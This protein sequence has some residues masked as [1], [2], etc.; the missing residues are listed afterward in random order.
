VIPARQAK[1]DQV[2]ARRSFCTGVLFGSSLEIQAPI[3][4]YGMI[5]LGIHPRRAEHDAIHCAIP[6]TVL[7]VNFFLKRGYT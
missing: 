1:V 3:K 7:N 2:I 5:T 4:L 6:E